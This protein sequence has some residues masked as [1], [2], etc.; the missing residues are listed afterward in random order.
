MD[1]INGML[2][3]D[4]IRELLKEGASTERA[5]ERIDALAPILDQ[6]RAEAAIEE[7]T[8]A[9][10][11]LDSLGTPPSGSTQEVREIAQEAELGSLL[12]AG[13]LDQIR[14]KLENML[15][16]SRSIFSESFVSNRNGHYTVPVK[17]EHKNKVPGTVIDASSTG[18]TVFIEPSAISRLREELETLRIEEENE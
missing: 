6:E 16:S 17:K 12:G 15:R 18:A 3:F 2:E 9:R 5:R 8:E 11:V 1:D 10:K 14:L 13:Q 4:K 7:T